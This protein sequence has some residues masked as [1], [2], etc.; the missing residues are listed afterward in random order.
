MVTVKETV[1]SGIAPITLDFSEIKFFE[2]NSKIIRTFIT[3]NSLDLGVLTYRQYRFVARRTK[4]GSQLVKRHLE[5]LFRLIPDILAEHPEIDCFTV[6]V[7]AKLL[8]DN[9]LEEMLR[10]TVEQ[11]PDVP[12]TKVCIELS[13]DILYE[14]LKAAAQM[15]NELRPLGVK[16]A[17]CEVGDEFCPIFRLSELNFDYA[18]LD[19][20]VTDSLDG[21]GAERI[22]G[23]LTSFLHHLSVKVV[24]PYLNSE[25]KIEGAKKVSVDG[26]TTETAPEDLIPRDEDDAPEEEEEEDFEDDESEEITPEAT[27]SEATEENEPKAEEPQAEDPET[28]V[29]EDEPE[30]T[31]ESAET[32]ENPETTEGIAEVGGDTD[33]Q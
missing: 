7:Y 9:E 6:P 8:A 23:N 30:S 26:Y 32:E 33:G 4:I 15:I 3:V 5:K 29:T 27:A 2:S 24:A 19:V 20:Y 13:A 31:E 14:D 21:E 17:I 10:E 28:A 11:F 22:A 16:I 12:L 25:E 1:E 18:F